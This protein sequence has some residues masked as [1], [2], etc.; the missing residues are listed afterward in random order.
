MLKDLVHF[1]CLWEQ[2]GAIEFHDFVLLSIHEPRSLEGL[3]S[4]GANLDGRAYV[5]SD[6]ANG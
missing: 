6:W 3:S 5:L 4:T 2:S 1:P